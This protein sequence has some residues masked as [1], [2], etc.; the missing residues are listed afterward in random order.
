VGIVEEFAKWPTGNIADALYAMGYMTAIHHEIRPIFT[1]ISLAGR[2][3]TVK[4]ERTKRQGDAEDVMTVCKEKSKP[5]DVIILACGGY[6]YGEPVLW[7]E[8]SMTACQVRGAVGAVIDGA[9]RDTARLKELKIPIF[10]RAISPGGRNGTLY[11]VDWNVPVVCGGIRVNPGDIV[12][13]DDDG[14]CIIPKEVEEEA[15]RIVRFYGE[16]DQAVAPALRQGKSV[17]EAYGIKKGWE[18]EAG[19][20]K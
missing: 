11:G 5:G 9:C 10:T 1:P 2:A 15:L 18:K 13:G 19:L 14:V 8:N 7:G 6:N 12:I 16:R 3:L 4:V 17:A 20:R